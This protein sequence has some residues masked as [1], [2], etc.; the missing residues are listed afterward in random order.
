MPSRRAGPLSFGLIVLAIIAV[1]AAPMSAFASALA[2]TGEP[3]IVP[4]IAGDTV[5]FSD[6]FERTTLGSGDGW[7]VTTNAN[8]TARIIV[9]GGHTGNGAR[10]TVPD[11]GNG[12]RAYIRHTLATPVY[13]ISEV[14]WFKVLSG[15]CDSSAGY[16]A[17][18]VPFI[19]FFDTNGARVAGL[20]RINGSCSKMAKLYVQYGGN[21]YRANKNIGFG[22]WNK[23]ELRITVDT[24]G[25]SLVQVYLNDIKVYE[26]TNANNGTLPI[27]STTTHNEHTNQ[28]GDLIADDITIG[29]F[30]APP[31]PPNP[32]VPAAADP[33]T[34][35]PGTTVL[36][37]GF[38]SYNFSK[39][40]AV[41]LAADGTALIQTSTVHTPLC[42]AQLHV[43]STTQS[44]ANLVKNLSSSEVYAD[45]WFDV[46]AEGASTSNVPEFRLFNGTTRVVSLYRVN[47]GG[48]LYLSVPNGSGGTSF[49]SLGQ[50]RALNTWFHYNVH[51][52]ANGS[53]STVVVT[54]DGV[55][56][57]GSATVP[58]GVSSFTSLMVGSE[59]VSQ[60]GDLNVDDVVIKTVP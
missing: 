14:G 35:D 13:A 11:Y 5:L 43:T 40:S 58:L 9:G 45:G 29:T 24:P 33:T 57:Y 7:T 44:K 60:V 16:S 6:S 19:R 25:S 23:M 21:Y 32:C 18:N 1:L 28:V 22:D 4:A 2:V 31:P 37:D 26:V 52:I 51:A 27:A 53:A 39:W 17:G 36:A 34:S 41:G 30:N 42:A 20:Y 10:M 38:D 49:I 8:G 59:V 47:V 15:G 3:N 54:V 46:T 48:Y 50:A 55:Q 56:R 12:S